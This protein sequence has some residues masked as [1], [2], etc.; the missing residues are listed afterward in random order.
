MINDLALFSINE[1][2]DEIS[3]ADLRYSTVE[4]CYYSIGHNNYLVFYIY[5]QYST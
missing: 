5:E 3:T 1:D 4:T 2:L